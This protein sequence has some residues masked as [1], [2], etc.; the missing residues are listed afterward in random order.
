MTA[1]I[2]LILV[3]DPGARIFPDRLFPVGYS[4]R[5]MDVTPPQGP[6]PRCL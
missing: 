2:V 1:N 6:P 4:I 5:L 3:L